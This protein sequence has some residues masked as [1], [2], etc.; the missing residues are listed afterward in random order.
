[1]QF[2][3]SLVSGFNTQAETDLS[4]HHGFSVELRQ[5]INQL[6][7]SS[8]INQSGEC[9]HVVQDPLENDSITISFGKSPPQESFG[10][11]GIPDC[12]PAIHITVGVASRFTI[13]QTAYGERQ[14]IRGLSAQEVRDHLLDFAGRVSGVNY[15]SAPF[16][17]DESYKKAVEHKFTP[18]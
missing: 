11:F 14:E 3:K 10:K 7:K 13:Q 17:L 2:D 6:E 15:Q 8:R 12:D 1:M 9:F 4:W 18:K 16:S 5:V